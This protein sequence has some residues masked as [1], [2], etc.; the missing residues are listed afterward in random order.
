SGDV[1]FLVVG[2][3]PER[4]ALAP[5]AGRVVHIARLSH[6]RMPEA[7]AAADL[8]ALPSVG[9]GLPLTLLEALSSGLRCVVSRDPSFAALA[10][11]DGVVPSD[12]STVALR[13]TIVKLLTE[14]GASRE[15]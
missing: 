13:D 14:S 3:G 9:E 10:S 12:V 6:D 2:D 7:Y 1:Q 5:L 8:F 11:C 4:G 15:R